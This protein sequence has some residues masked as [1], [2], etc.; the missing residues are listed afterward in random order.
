VRAGRTTH[1]ILARAMDPSIV[2]ESPPPGYVTQSP[3]T[4]Y[5][6]EKLMFERWAAMSVDEKIDVI[7][8]T[9]RGAH[10][11]TLAGLSARHPTSSAEQLELMAAELRIGADAV[12]RLLEDSE[13]RE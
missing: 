10:H 5:W 4:A 1:A 11:L 3:D 6:V 9:C 12:R 2:R 7:R 8:Q 13:G